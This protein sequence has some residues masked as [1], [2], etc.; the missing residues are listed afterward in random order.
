M[1][2]AALLLVAI[3]LFIAMEIQDLNWKDDEDDAE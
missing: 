1:L 3:A 2:A